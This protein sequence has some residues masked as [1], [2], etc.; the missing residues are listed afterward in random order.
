MYGTLTEFE[1]L[2][3]Q[4]DLFLVRRK[5]LRVSLK[6]KN[7]SIKPNTW[8][9]FLLFCFGSFCCSNKSSILRLSVGRKVISFV[10]LLANL[11]MKPRQKIYAL[12][13][14]WKEEEFEKFARLNFWRS[15]GNAENLVQIPRNYRPI[16][17]QKSCQRKVQISRHIFWNQTKLQRFKV[18][19]N[20]THRLQCRPYL[21]LNQDDV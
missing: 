10:L 8:K 20:P 9:R 19:Q 18:S 15:Y 21:L 17:S 3:L 6:P 4:F 7:S 2:E 12:Y 5:V 11:G 1:P 13:I 16:F 14:G